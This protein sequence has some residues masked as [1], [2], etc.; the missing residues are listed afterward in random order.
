[1]YP[2]L[3]KNRDNTRRRDVRKVK[4]QTATAHQRFILLSPLLSLFGV[5]GQLK[6]QSQ[7]GYSNIMSVPQKKIPEPLEAPLGASQVPPRPDDEL[8][9]N[10]CQSRQLDVVPKECL[11]GDQE[12]PLMH[13]DVS[14]HK[15]L[16]SLQP[17]KYSVMFI[18]IVELLERFSFYGYYYVSREPFIVF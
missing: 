9:T 14:G 3:A 8:P 4:L 2:P 6:L 13:V 11:S 7:E 18:L 10:I 5:Q 17:M 12:R 1:M 16:Y 15:S